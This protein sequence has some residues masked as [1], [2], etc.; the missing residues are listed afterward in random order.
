MLHIYSFPTFNLTKLLYTAEELGMP[1]TSHLLKIGEH[2][3]PEHLARHP[4]GKVPAAEL[5]GQYYFESNSICR[6]MAELNGNKLYGNTPEQRAHINEWM[7]VLSQQFG[8]WLSTYFFEEAVK[9]GLLK[10]QTNPAAVEEAAGLSK[11]ELPV[12]DKVLGSRRFIA[13]NDITLADTIGF[14]VFSVKEVTS[15]D[16][17]AYPNIET[18][19]QAMK[20]R[21]SYARAL[22]NLPNSNMFAVFGK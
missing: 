4:M 12:L 3:K 15:M 16:L 6:L 9:P 22:A 17:S 10:G 5:N 19:Y 18:W 1:Y 14:S 7:D 21:P 11:Q 8:R 20:A 13:G 2:K